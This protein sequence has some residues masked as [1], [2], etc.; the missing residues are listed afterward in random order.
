MNKNWLSLH[1]VH[2]ELNDSNQHK[3]RVVPIKLDDGLVTQRNQDQIVEMKAE[4]TKYSHQEFTES[5]TKTSDPTA[6]ATGAGKTTTEQQFKEIPRFDT[7]ENVTTMQPDTQNRMVKERVI[8]ITL[9]NT[10]ETITPSFIQLE[11]PQP[12]EWS[13]FSQRNM[14]NRSSK[15]TI[16][17]IR[18]VDI[19]DEESISVAGSEYE[20]APQQKQNER[21]KPKQTADFCENENT[22]AHVDKTGTRPKSKK[23]SSSPNSNTFT[24]P[25]TSNGIRGATSSYPKNAPNAERSNIPET[26]AGSPKSDTPKTPKK[27]PIIKNKSETKTDT[28]KIL[29][30]TTETTKTTTEKRSQTVRFNLDDDNE[31][32]DSKQTADQRNEKKQRFENSRMR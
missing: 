14:A 24:D 27:S 11:D 6:T 13:A 23:G 17:P 28:K 16:V 18:L 31:D 32:D 10:G 7:R 15:E 4:F 25:S 3:T 2:P 8:P 1:L 12:P 20:N 9:E 5:S 29:S 22:T 26:S 21:V 19:A 30:K